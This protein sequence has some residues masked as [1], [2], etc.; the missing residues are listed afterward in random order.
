MDGL[1][2]VNGQYCP[3]SEARVHVEDRGFQF[4]DGVYEV[5]VAYH[6]RAFRLGDH[7]ERLAASASGIGLPLDPRNGTIEAVIT[8]GLK[9][10]PWDNVVVY[11]QITR[12]VMGRSHLIPP[13]PKCTVV[14]TFKPKQEVEA[15]VRARGLHVITCEDIRWAWPYL[16]TIALLPNVLARERARQ[17]GA[18]DAIFLGP[19]GEVREATAANVFVVRE[20]RVLTPPRSEKI[21]HGITR[22]VVLEIA[23][24]EGMEAREAALRREDLL[25]AEEVFITSTT[26]EVIGVTQVDGKAV[27]SGAVGPVTQRLYEA[28]RGYVEAVCRGEA[29]PGGAARGGE[30][31]M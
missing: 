1:A 5:I 17:Q 22:A 9:R 25:E 6:R 2:W 31:P 29:A 15:E 14:L 23:E 20:G 4:A 30:K 24:A 21:L 18:D 26:S 19:E 3:L 28:F 27:G 10:V 13:D 7:L 12:G 16:K 8:E 11:V